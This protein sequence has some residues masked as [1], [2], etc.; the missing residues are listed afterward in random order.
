MKFKNIK[1][2]RL[3]AS[4]IMALARKTGSILKRKPK[5]KKLVE[6]VKIS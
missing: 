4:K 3:S 2:Q 5:T 1:N 6:H